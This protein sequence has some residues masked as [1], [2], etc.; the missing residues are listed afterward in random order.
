[1]KRLI[2]IAVVFCLLITNAY[3]QS[4]GLNI[5][6]MA[7][8]ISLPNLSGDTIT[9]SSMKDKIVLI[10]FWA[11][12]CAPCVSE[13]SKLAELYKKFK[14]SEFTGGNGFE[15][16]G[17]S[18][19]NKRKQWQN[20]IKKYNIEWTQVSDLK[21]WT[22]AVAKLYNIQDL[23]FNLLINGKGIIIAKNLHGAELEQAINKL[24]IH[25]DK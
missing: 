14:H 6:D 2:L 22:S 17:V 19:D 8:D 25:R 10:D 11:S 15:I 18:L 1:M 9:L 24:I 7:P 23:P 13:Q 21:F 3:S 20:V 16:Y 12:W 5:G 4:R